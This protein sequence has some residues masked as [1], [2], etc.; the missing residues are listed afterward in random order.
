MPIKPSYIRLIIT[1]KTHTVNLWWYNHCIWYGENIITVLVK[2]IHQNNIY[3]LHSYLTVNS[4]HFHY[5]NKSVK[6]I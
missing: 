4:M 2:L 3:K 5:K 1:N 6:G